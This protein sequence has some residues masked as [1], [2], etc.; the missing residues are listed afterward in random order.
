[1]SKKILVVNTGGTIA[2]SV[3]DTEGVKPLDDQ[4]VTKNLPFFGALCGRHHEKLPESA[5][6]AHDSQDYE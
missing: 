6:P 1:M 2:M 4:A 5:K 3:D